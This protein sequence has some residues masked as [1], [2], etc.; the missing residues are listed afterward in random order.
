MRIFKFWKKEN[1]QLKIDGTLQPASAYGGS[2]ISIEDAQADAKN[3]LKKAQD[4]IDGI[5]MRESYQADI[6]EEIIEEIDAENIITRNR[7]GAL[8]LNAKNLMFIDIDNYQ[9][10]HT[11]TFF[12]LFG[13]KK[14]TQKEL[15]LDKIEE[16][17]ANPAYSR[18]GFRI[19]ETFKGY[20]VM[21]TGKNFSPTSEESKSIMKDFSA[22]ELYQYLCIK[23][24]C[25]RARL[26][27]KP[28]RMNLKSHKT[29][30]PERTAAEQNEHQDWVE[31]YNAESNNYSS[32]W[33]IKSYGPA[34][35][36]G[37]I[38]YHD[39]ITKTAP[40]KKLA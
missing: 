30:F 3:R 20:R 14:K 40:H 26:T 8:V 5:A 18:L 12:G 9:G 28:Y 11:F 17:I 32:C 16:T 24:N 7:Y 19:Y 35:S 39:R 25:Y 4:I 36:S 38:Q 22:D 27:P 33:F 2:N 13:K 1:T 29:I 37:V 15:I 31:K 10:K 6:V 23:Q 21:V 34:Y